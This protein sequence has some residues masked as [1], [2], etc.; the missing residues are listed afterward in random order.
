[1]LTIRLQRTGRTHETTFRI[2]VTDSKN[3]TKS[4]KSLEVVGSYDPRRDSATL[5][6]EDRVK[7]WISMGASL[8]GTVNNLLISKKIIEGKKVNVLPKKTVP[9]KEGIKEETPAE[10]VPTEV[11]A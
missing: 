9:K 5:I 11:A 1:M 10:V 8:S 3:S 7:H 6:K 2:V 4:G